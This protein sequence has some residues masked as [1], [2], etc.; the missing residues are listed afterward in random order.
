MVV[1]VKD[2]A[3]YPQFSDYQDTFS[4]SLPPA[5]FA[6]FVVPTWV[7][8]SAQLL[9][10]AKCVYPYWRERRIERGGQRIIP[11]LNVSYCYRSMRPLRS[12]R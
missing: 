12:D 7:P 5:T 1:Q 8:Q 9:R 3:N 2:P 11:I 4:S 10:F 6:V